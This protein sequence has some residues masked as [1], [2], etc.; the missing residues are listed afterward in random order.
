[1]GAVEGIGG[2]YDRY[3]HAYPLLAELVTSYLSGIAV[4]SSQLGWFT[5]LL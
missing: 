5:W 3:A 4:Y 1:M 2:V